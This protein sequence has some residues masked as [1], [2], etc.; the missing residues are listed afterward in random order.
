MIY[1]ADT[2]IFS[3]VRAMHLFRRCFHFENVLQF[4]QFHTYR[5]TE[6]V[7]INRNNFLPVELLFKSARFMFIYTF[8]HTFMVE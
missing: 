3:S 1:F 5:P 6:R 2:E 8:V 4:L 7:E